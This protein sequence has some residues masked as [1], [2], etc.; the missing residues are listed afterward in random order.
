MAFAFFAAERI[1]VVI[2]VDV[3]A[4]VAG[5]LGLPMTNEGFVVKAVRS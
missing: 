4:E 5:N 1:E 3:V 2:A